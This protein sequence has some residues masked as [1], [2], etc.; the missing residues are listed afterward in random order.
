MSGT[1]EAGKSYLLGPN[2]F[3][4]WETVN[5]KTIHNNRV[6]MKQVVAGQSASFG[7]KKV[8]RASVRKG[9]VI[10]VKEAEP[11]ACWEFSAEVLIL[12]HSTTIQNGYEAVIHCN[13]VRQ[14]ARIEHMETETLRT[15]D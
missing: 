14:T 2:C 3:G 7:L 8:K 5:V 15:R 6:P 10:V 9:M 11:K 13:A 12:Y 4:A 1:A